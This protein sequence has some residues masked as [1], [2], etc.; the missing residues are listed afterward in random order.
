MRMRNWKLSHALALTS[1]F[2][3]RCQCTGDDAETLRR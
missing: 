2:F 1:A 3:A